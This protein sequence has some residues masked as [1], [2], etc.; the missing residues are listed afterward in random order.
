MPL[1]VVLELFYS[2]AV[3]PRFLEAPQLASYLVLK[4]PKLCRS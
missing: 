2:T 4:C 1:E 3:S